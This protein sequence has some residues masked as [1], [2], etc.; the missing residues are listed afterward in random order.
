MSLPPTTIVLP[1]NWSTS[2]Q[3]QP[4]R[5]IVAHDTERPNNNTNSI[6][7]LQ[8]GGSAA[9]GSDRK[10]SIH[11]LIEPNGDIYEMVADVLGANH[12]GFSKLT[13]AGVTYSKTSKYNV[14]QISLGFELEYTKAPYHQPYPEAQLLSMGWW[15]NQKRDQWGQIPIYRHGDIDTTGKTDPRGLSVAEIEHWCIR[16]MQITTT[17]FPTPDNPHAYVMKVPQV[18]YTDRSIASPFAG[19]HDAPVVLNAGEVVMVGDLTG[20]WL[21]LRDGIGFIPKNTTYRQQ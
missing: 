8:R 5:C 12:A 17:P 11:G 13:I 6:K 9:D 14:N 15:I 16:A 19:T 20:D 21:W 7:Y 10:V 3:G 18:V 1:A 2:R 4:I